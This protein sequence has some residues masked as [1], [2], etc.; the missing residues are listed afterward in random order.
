MKRFFFGEHVRFEAFSDHVFTLFC[1][2]HE[3]CNKIEIMIYLIIKNMTS[4]SFNNVQTWQKFDHSKRH[5]KFYVMLTWWWRW[6]NKLHI[7]WWRIFLDSFCR[8]THSVAFSKVIVYQ[9]FFSIFLFLLKRI[10]LLFHMWFILQQLWLDE[11]F[12]FPKS[13][14]RERNNPENSS[15]C[16][17]EYLFSKKHENKPKKA[18]NHFWRNIWDFRKFIKI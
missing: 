2:R 9:V 11:F 5:W 18:E 12:D 4:A 17:K 3:T 16:D 15:K 14:C 7:L 13:I 1:G 8:L 6:W 10:H